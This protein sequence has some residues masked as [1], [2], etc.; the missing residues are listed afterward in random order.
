MKRPTPTTLSLIALV[1]TALLGSSSAAPVEQG[2]KSLREAV[3]RNEIVPLKSIMTWI[4][5]N[6]H[7]QVV[8]VELEN[9]GG[10]FNYEIDLLSPAGTKI[11]FQFNARTGE[12]QSISG[13][14]IEKA[15]RK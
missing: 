4:E 3:E 12:L 9:D 13:K 10:F 11:E 14:D 2:S 6:Y 7:G 1:L 15:K 8:E 5:D